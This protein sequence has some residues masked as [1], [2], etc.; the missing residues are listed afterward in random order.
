M[1]IGGPASSLRIV[2][3]FDAPPERVFDAWIDPAIAGRWLF[4][5]PTSESHATSMEVRIGGRWTIT[6][7]RDG[8]TYTAIGEYVEID[9][10]RRLVFTFEMPQFSPNADRV[11]VE[12]VPDRSGCV[13]TLTQ[14]GI[15][16]AGELEQLPPGATGDSASGWGS[17][18][19]ELAALL[20]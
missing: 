20:G 5:G 16:I 3:R 10:P 1:A 17:M 13:L 14:E 8:V 15:D 7:V 18:F 19:D 6:D 9:R 2:R 12:I 11:T 4:T